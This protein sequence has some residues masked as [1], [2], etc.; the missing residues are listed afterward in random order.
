MVYKSIMRWRQGRF[1]IIAIMLVLAGCATAPRTPPQAAAP[2]PL[3]TAGATVYHVVKHSSQIRIRVRSAGWLAGV[4]GHEHLVTTSDIQ[5]N[6]YVHPNPVE[7]GFDLRIPLQS[8]TVDNPAQRRRAAPPFH[9]PLGASA[10]AGTRR[11]MLGPRELDATRYPTMTLRSVAVTGPAT[12]PRITVRVSLHGASHDYTVPT[13]VVRSGQR[14]V[15]LGHLV[16][17][18]TDFAITPYNILAG[19]LRVADPLAVSFHIV[20]APVPSA[21]SR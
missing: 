21:A 11:H 13:T 17:R 18:Q 8:L 12:R 3:P 10:R 7:T 19:G 4:L 9:K 15:A 1:L 2:P 6:I 14:L 16:V 5:G 20:A